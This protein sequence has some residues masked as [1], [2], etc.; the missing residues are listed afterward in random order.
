MPDSANLLTMEVMIGLG[1]LIVILA[2]SAG[3]LLVRDRVFGPRDR[4]PAALEEAQ[5]AWEARLLAPDWPAVERQLGRPAPAVLRELYADHALL[6]G[7]PFIVSGSETDGEAAWHIHSFQPADGR[8]DHFEIP[9]GAFC[10]A[11]TEFGDPYYVELAAGSDDGPVSL[12]YHDGGDVER[13]ADSL[14][15]F[16]GWPRRAHEVARNEPSTGSGPSCRFCDSQGPVPGALGA[17]PSKCITRVA[18][19]SRRW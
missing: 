12:G 15:E 18:P 8:G 17:H 19:T 10:F 6:R 14:T 3:I 13:V 11:M 9:P 7:T 1:F 4:S 2:F 5:I 16:L